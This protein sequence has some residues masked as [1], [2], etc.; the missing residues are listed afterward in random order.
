M[1]LGSG[2]SKIWTFLDGAGQESKTAIMGTRA[3]AAWLCSIVFD[4]TRA[5]EGASPDRQLYGIR[6]SNS[7]RK[8][9]LKT[10]ASAGERVRMTRNSIREFDS[11]I[12]RQT[13]VV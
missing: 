11:R 8:L 1:A 5:S 2:G 12:A 13:G 4:G 9:Y 10:S 7:A 6:S 3:H